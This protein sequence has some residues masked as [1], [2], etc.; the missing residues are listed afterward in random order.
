MNDD[1]KLLRNKFRQVLDNLEPDRI[2]FAEKS[3]FAYPGAINPHRTRIMIGLSGLRENI[4]HCH[5]QTG[6]F[7]MEKGDLFYASSDTWHKPLCHNAYSMLNI[8]YDD[9]FTRIGF[10]EQKLNLESS[11]RRCV[12]P[13]LKATMPLYHQIAAVNNLDK[14]N[15]TLYAPLMIETILRMTREFLLSAKQNVKTNKPEI[16]WTDICGYLDDNF[17]RNISRHSVARSFRMHPNHLSRLFRQQ[18]GEGFFDRLNRLRMEHAMFLLQT[19]Q[20]PSVKE[21]A[22]RCGFNSLNYFCKAFKDF[23]GS[24]PGEYRNR[25]D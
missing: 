17:H 25:K 3:L 14:P 16:L 21:I 10:R 11:D 22:F 23:S 15:D 19:E 7:P 20:N 9:K 4:F 18:G 6:R 24:S 13:P 12:L 1:I 8:T 2:L 5:G